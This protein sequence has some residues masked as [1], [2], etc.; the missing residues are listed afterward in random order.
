MVGDD[1]RSV[2]SNF[3]PD[4]VFMLNTKHLFLKQILSNMLIWENK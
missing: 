3:F 1:F 2:K 4:T